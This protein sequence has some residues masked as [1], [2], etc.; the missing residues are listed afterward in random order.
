MENK[1]AFIRNSL[2]G[3]GTTA[4]V[5]GGTTAAGPAQET[6]SNFKCFHSREICISGTAKLR[7]GSRMA[8]R[9]GSGGPRGG[10]GSQRPS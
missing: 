8:T 4:G 1:L 2:G 7:Q 9:H 10:G 6:G 3:G 5:Q